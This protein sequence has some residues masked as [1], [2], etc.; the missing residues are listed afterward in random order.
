MLLLA[1]GKPADTTAESVAIHPDYPMKAELV[2]GGVYAIITPAR[3][4]PNKQNK[5]WNSNS[6]FVVTN[7]GVLVVDTGS[8]TL[9]GETLLKTIRTVTD[10]PIK[11]IVCTHG[12]GDHWLGTSALMQEATELIVS[13]KQAKRMANELE[14]WADLFDRMTDGAIGKAEA[15]QPTTV[16]TQATRRD[17][18][19]LKAELI[20]SGDSHSPGDVL[21]WLPKQKVLITGDVVYTT[22]LPG[23]FE[24]DL[25]QW[26]SFLAELEKL[27]VK[28]VIPG[29][30][31]IGTK[32]DITRQREFQQ[33][34]WD[35]TA[36]GF[37]E[38]LEAFEIVPKVQEKT[39][40]YKD[41][42]PGYDERL[43]ESVSHFY[44]QVEAA[45]F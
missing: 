24:G 31:G 28:K 32:D 7:D 12:H 18:G 10:K 40:Q 26:I 9:I 44:L 25:Q 8:S 2:A 29:H 20:L 38:G 21:V 15:V 16:L 27:P 4:F 36:A 13:E 41:F 34:I 22:R 42:Y 14:Y 3:D 5:G 33:T 11:W 30:G 23:T 39:A 17:F 45:A 19:G 1:C 35:I 37:D 43:P 6:S